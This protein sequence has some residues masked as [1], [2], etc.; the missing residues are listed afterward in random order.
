MIE[1][2]QL[3]KM[4]C[5]LYS[6]KEQCNYS[7]SLFI[8]ANYVKFRPGPSFSYPKRVF[9]QDKKKRQR[10]CSAKLLDEHSWAHYNIG[11]DLIFCD[12]CVKATKRGNTLLQ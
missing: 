3:L 8:D 5:S 7:N 10:C 2:L 11:K 6:C 1:T 9:G 12:V 4:S